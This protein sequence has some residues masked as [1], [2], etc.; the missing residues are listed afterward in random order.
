VEGKPKI[1][2]P[3]KVEDKGFVQTLSDFIG[4][5]KMVF[6]V[7]AGAV[8]AVLLFVGIFSI[9]SNS[10][11]NSSARAM[12]Q[13]REKITSYS[14][15]SDATKKADLEK[16]LVA[17]LDAV[18]KKWPRSFA[19]QEALYSEASL[20]ASKKDWVNSEKSALAAATK[21]PK[22]Y[23]APLALE[24]A[25]VAAEEQAKPDVA[26]ETYGKI[27]VQYKE[28]SPNLPHAYFSIARLKEGKSDW[29]G[30]LES[31]DKLVSSFPDSDWAKLAKDRQIFLQ[32][33]G[34]DKK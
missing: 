24:V 4:K 16:A 7:A 6:I 19:A 33:K 21:L 31:Y 28:D 26:L 18:A 25:A 10:I 23:L 27:I 32:S 1:I 5:H 14:E 11:A 8:V 13:A 3:D 2:I 20:Y 34:Y 22:T 9:A 30:A 29:K 17:D 15:E 12:E